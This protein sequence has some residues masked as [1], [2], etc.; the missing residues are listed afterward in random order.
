VEIKCKAS[1]EIVNLPYDVSDVVKKGD[2]VV[3]LDPVDEQREVRRAEVAL[4]ATKARLEQ[5]KQ[6]LKIAE[7]NLKT[8]KRKAEASIAAAQVRYQD[9]YAKA[10]RAKQLLEKNLTSKEEF[11][12]L[13][14]A[15]ASAST[16]LELAK[17]RLEELKVQEMALELKRQDIVLMQMQVESDEISLSIAQQRLKDT[18]V[19]APIDGVVSKRDVQIGQIIS[20]GISNV[21]GGTT[22]MVLSDLSRIFVLAA[23]DESDIGKVKN[24]QPVRITVDAFPMKKFWGKV[25]RIATKGVVVSNVVTFE[26]KIEVMG[27]DRVLLKPEMTANVEIIAEQKESVL[28]VP[29]DSVLRKNGKQIVTVMKPDGSKEEKAVQVGISD[30][31]KVEIL[32]GLEEGETVIVQKSETDSKWRSGQTCLARHLCLVGV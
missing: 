31:V 9:A 24:G 21:G 14:T 2:L 18:K 5:A 4:G 10:E 11:E 22:V 29:S 28:L 17:I 25:V 6:N 27:E 12:T 30:G 23:V 15:V 1:G 26:V 7:E 3:E 8:E 20:S 32:N 13:L 19:Y 16:E